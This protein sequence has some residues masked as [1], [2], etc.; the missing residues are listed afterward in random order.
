VRE[1]R[2]ADTVL[3]II[4]ERGKQGLPL[5][6]LYRQL[7]NPDLYLR[8]YARLYANNGAMTPGATSETVDAM[9]LAKIA[10]L[11]DDLRHER[12]RW[13]PVRRT[14][15]PKKDGKKLRPL[16]LPSWSDKLLQEVMR[17]LLEAYYEPQFSDHSHGFRPGRGGHTALTTVKE[18][19]TGTKWYIEGDISQCFERIDHQVL[20]SILREK[21]LD[22][23]FLRLVQTLLQAGYL[24]DWQY[25]ATR[26]G[27]P[28]G[29]IVSPILSNVYLDKLDKYVERELLPA[30]TR[31]HERQKNRTYFALM[32]KAYKRRKK[33]KLDE[34]VALTKEAQH[35]PTV[36]PHDPAYRRLHDVRYA[37]DWL[38]GF[39]GTK[40]EAEV[41][42]GRLRAFLRET[43][44]LE[45]S[46]EKTL[47]THATTG[48]A[49]FLGYE[50]VTQQNDEKRDHSGHRTL[51]GHIGLRLPHEVVEKKRALHMRGGKAIPRAELLFND[52]YTIVNQYQTEYRGL[53]QYY[54]LAQN[55]AWLWRLHWV[56]PTSLLKT[57]ASK[58]KASLKQILRH[59]RTT[60]TT[61][62]GPMRCLEVV[63]ERDGKKPLV[64][65][66][67]GIPLRRRKE[68]VLIDRDPPHIYFRRNE[69]IKRLLVGACELC[70]SMEDCAVH[71]VRKLADLRKKG[72]AEKPPWIRV[73]ASR[74]RKTLVVCGRCHEAIHAGRPPQQRASA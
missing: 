56:M 53:V 74:R 59:Y 67:G 51:N 40:A 73:M 24:E 10:T 5:G 15:I 6:D 12:H 14:Y 45:L 2:R 44:T 49:R 18:T 26:S 43:L 37:D 64:A 35:L 54:L 22:N 23:R 48:A 32:T 20:L 36:D 17:S 30:Y 52:D 1:I 65:R 21:I 33:G 50:I 68:A 27:T 31:G 39:V 61:P 4:R 57:L 70:G 71:H 63:V 46:Q 47:I 66:F 16:G 41:I 55:V 8:A 29:S 28:Q 3:G 13:T 58:H 9:S 72:R 60:I 69:L 42:K 25:H 62:Y 19:W 11:I 38:M 7:Y 34:A